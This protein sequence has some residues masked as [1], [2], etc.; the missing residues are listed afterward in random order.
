[1]L[2]EVHLHLPQSIS[3]IVSISLVVPMLADDIVDTLDCAKSMMKSIISVTTPH[4]VTYNVPK[5][6]NHCSIVCGVKGLCVIC[7]HGETLR[8]V[9]GCT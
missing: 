9:R 4:F 5:F 1:M 6:A 7:V 3:S 2:K 8:E